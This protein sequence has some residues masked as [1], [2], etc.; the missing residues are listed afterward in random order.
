MSEDEVEYERKK[1]LNFLDTPTMKRWDFGKMVYRIISTNYEP[2][3]QYVM[4]GMV[5]VPY[6]LSPFSTCKRY[7][8]Q[9]SYLLLVSTAVQGRKYIVSNAKINSEAHVYDIY[10]NTYSYFNRAN[11]SHLFIHIHIYYYGDISTYCRQD[12]LH[13]FMFIHP[14]AQLN[15]TNL[16]IWECHIAFVSA[17]GSIRYGTC[18]NRLALPDYISM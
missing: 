1:V 13:M 3:V 4:Y 8:M 2:S 10:V 14:S 12:P 16:E 9:C 17:K 6:Y 11:Q 7:C 5:Y 18:N 15:R